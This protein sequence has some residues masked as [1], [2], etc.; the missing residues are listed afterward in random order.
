VR[1]AETAGEPRLAL[2]ARD[3]D[4]VLGQLRPE[5]LERNPLSPLVPGGEDEPGRPLAEPLLQAVPADD[6]PRRGE[7]AHTGM[8][9]RFRLLGPV[10]ALVDD[11]PAKLPGGKPRAL[12]VRLL[13]EPGRV[14]PVD[15]LFDDLW[16][17][18]PASALKIVQVYVSQLR[19]ALGPEIIETRSPGYLVQ[20]RAGESD[21]GRFER[22]AEEAR[23]TREPTRRAALLREALA[24]W[25]GPAL[26]EFRDEPFADAAARRLAELRLY[27]LE[28]RIE[29]DLELGEHA[30]LVSELEALVEQEP[31]RERPRGQLMLALYRSGRQAEAL[32]HYRAGRALLVDQLG[33]EPGP[34]L[35]ELEGAILRQERSLAEEPGRPT[36]RGSVVCAALELAGL[37]AALAGEDRE[38]VLVDLVA[39]AA[40]LRGRAAALD[41]LGAE[42]GGRTASFVS[43]SPG[44]DYARL[45]AEQHAEL[46]LCGPLDP[47]ELELLLAGAPCDVALAP[48]PDLRFQPH[49][50][51]LVPFGGDRD[52]WAGLELAAWIARA[53]GLPLR[54]LG[55]EAREGRRDASRLLAGAS[56]ALQRF[57]GTTAEPV[58]GPPGLGG[59]LAEPG[60]LL[61][62][63]LPAKGLDPTRAELARRTTVPLLLVRGGLRPS[64]LAPDQTLTRFTWSLAER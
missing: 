10:E 44:S 34:A 1:R 55:T 46:L 2:E 23:G 27:A 3:H 45:T 6:L 50:A 39:E 35:Q 25:R 38:L 42:H 36:A 56:L 57:A 58:L 62:A 60:S 59:I 43:Q 48:R 18:P 26:A 8:M 40:D 20:A 4:A 33:I 12:L 14:V 51:V 63:S 17:E 29:A 15:T 30:R 24:L 31:L 11:E 61:V 37:A 13:L 7:L 16:H 5:Q 54:L 9:I 47:A 49:G 19:K 28:E 52:E 53:H 41:E 32:E 22:L 64:G 21:L